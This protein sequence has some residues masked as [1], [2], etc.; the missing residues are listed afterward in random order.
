MEGC[1]QGVGRVGSAS[2]GGGVYWG[3]NGVDILLV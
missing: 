1:G 3:G 2:L